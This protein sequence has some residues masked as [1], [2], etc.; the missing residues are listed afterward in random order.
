LTADRAGRTL[1]ARFTHDKAPIDGQRLPDPS[2]RALLL[3]IARETFDDGKPGVTHAV[4]TGAARENL[5][6]QV[7][8][9]NLLV[10]GMQG[11]DYDRAC[12]QPNDRRPVSNSVC[13][14]PFGF[15]RLRVRLQPGELQAA[16]TQ[17]PRVERRPRSARI[18]HGQL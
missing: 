5:A 15:R 10:H 9:R 4:G 12:E 11:F 2:G 7:S 6:L 18:S 3:F 8:E 1:P 14:G 16:L 13:E 17:V